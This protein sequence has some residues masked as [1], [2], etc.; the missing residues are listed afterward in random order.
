MGDLRARL[1][2][3]ISRSATVVLSTQIHQRLRA[4]LGQQELLAVVLSG[5]AILCTL[6]GSLEG[7]NAP[8][9]AL[10]ALAQSLSIQLA[11][12]YLTEG[13]RPDA[14]LFNLIFALVVAE[15]AGGALEGDARDLATGV[16]YIAS[17]RLTAILTALGAPLVGISVGVFFGGQGLLGQTLALTGVNA[18]CAAAFGAVQ[19]TSSLALAW[20]IVLL[21]FVHEAVRRFDRAEA[22]LDYGLYK[23]SD[24]VYVGL[25]QFV[26]VDVLA[27]LLFFLVA[28]SPTKDEVWTGVCALALV[29]A[30]SDWFLAGMAQAA[31]ADLL[32]GGVCVVTVVHFATAVVGRREDGG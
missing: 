31:Q 11:V 10:R 24:A 19:A 21:Y 16:S 22:F 23:A 26:R 28:A 4:Y 6:P 5:H 30:A 32:L 3:G 25:S 7:F 15:G 2:D 20:P 17:D 9:R 29:R 12:A 27:L 14:G 8:W 1:L 18:L 13:Q